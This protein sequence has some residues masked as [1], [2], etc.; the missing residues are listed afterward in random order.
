MEDG[1]HE[2]HDAALQGDWEHVLSF[3]DKGVNPDIQTTDGFTPLMFASASGSVEA[4]RALLDRGA[5]PA[6]R[7]EQDTAA[8]W[9]LTEAVAALLKPSD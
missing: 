7:T 4:V 1:I 8:E 3:L 2:I 6:F 9:A 5:N